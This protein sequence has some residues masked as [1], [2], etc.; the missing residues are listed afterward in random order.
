[1]CS[2]GGILLTIYCIFKSSDKSVVAVDVSN[3]CSKVFYNN[4][5]YSCIVSCVTNLKILALDQ[6][7]AVTY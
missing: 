6:Q 2:G 5:L 1:M 3:L 7:I 4:I